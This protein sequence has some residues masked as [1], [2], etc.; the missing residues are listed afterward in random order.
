M[1]GLEIHKF[2]GLKS[3]AR[4]SFYFDDDTDC[5][6]QRMR[7]RLGSDSIAPN[8]LRLKSALLLSKSCRGRGSGFQSLGCGSDGNGI[9]TNLTVKCR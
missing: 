2:A 4:L 5:T 6:S 8:L 7:A 1:E 9:G 3:E